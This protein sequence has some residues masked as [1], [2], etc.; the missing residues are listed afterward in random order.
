MYAW[1]FSL[2]SRYEV[3]R[4]Q[5]GVGLERSVLIVVSFI[6]HTSRRRSRKLLTTQIAVF[7]AEV[8]GTTVVLELASFDGPHVKECLVA[9]SSGVR[10]RRLLAFWYV[11]LCYYAVDAY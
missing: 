11:H 4:S 10:L 1:P 3:H 2:D 8:I 7:V 9:H 6:V 5:Y